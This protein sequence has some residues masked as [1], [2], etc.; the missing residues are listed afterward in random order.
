MPESDLDKTEQ[1]WQA[2]VRLIGMNRLE[3]LP[4][5][6]QTFAVHIRPHDR[7]RYPGFK[8]SYWLNRRYVTSIWAKACRA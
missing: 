2:A 3:E 5:E 8:R 1:V 4:V 6:A 7:R